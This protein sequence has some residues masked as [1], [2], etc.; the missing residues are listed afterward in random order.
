MQHEDYW[1]VEGQTPWVYMLIGLPCSGKTTFLESQEI[2]VGSPFYY[3]V[4]SDQYVEAAAA[5]LDT[6]Y[7]KVFHDVQGH[8]QQAV[9]NKVRKYVSQGV[10]F[11][12]DQTNLTVKTRRHKLKMIPTEWRR[13]AFFFVPDFEVILERNKL[14]GEKTGKVIPKKA[15]EDMYDVYDHPRPNEG[16]DR[17]DYMDYEGKLLWSDTQLREIHPLMVASAFGG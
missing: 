9:Y 13:A 14:R 2:D 10:S 1:I 3:S 7:E 4:S 11:T 6:T 5:V 12:W 17:I 8:A 15:L 16:F